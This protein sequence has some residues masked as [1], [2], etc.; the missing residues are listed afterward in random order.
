MCYS[1]LNYIVLVYFV[2]VIFNKVV[3]KGCVNYERIVLY[4]IRSLCSLCKLVISKFV[5]NIKMSSL[6]LYFLLEKY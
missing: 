1:L 2:L 3:F 5:I 4:C 6:R